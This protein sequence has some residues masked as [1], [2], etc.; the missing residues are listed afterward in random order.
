[1][2]I[3][4]AGVNCHSNISPMRS[5]SPPSSLPLLSDKDTR[6]I[7]PHVPEFY[8]IPLYNASRSHYYLSCNGFPATPVNVFDKC[9]FFQALCFFLR[10]CGQNLHYLFCSLQSSFPVIFAL[11]WVRVGLHQRKTL[12]QKLQRS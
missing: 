11:G 2:R 8:N 4:L 10:N 9:I 12:S 6:Q 5:V 3:F 7:L 1:M